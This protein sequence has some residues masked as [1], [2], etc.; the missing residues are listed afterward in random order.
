MK[1]NE[2]HEGYENQEKN[3]S[4]IFAE[5]STSV[6]RSSELK[7]K[8]E[9][10]R[11]VKKCFVKR[12][13]IA[14]TRVTDLD[15][16]LSINNKKINVFNQFS[17]QLNKGQLLTISEA[18][19]RK[20][21]ELEDDKLKSEALLLLTKFALYFVKAMDLNLLASAINNNV[22]VDFI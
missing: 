3:R 2:I 15:N 1:T 5:D 21:I 6:E 19:L 10:L 7:K 12:Q 22:K 18:K 17:N 8:I 14:E 13:R 16:I 20:A 4:G 11:K 9:Q